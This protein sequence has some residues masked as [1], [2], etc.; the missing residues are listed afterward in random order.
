MLKQLKNL[1]NPT[2]ELLVMGI[3]N[4]TPDSFYD[5]GEFLNIND[6]IKQANKMIQEGVDIIDLGGFTSNNSTIKSSGCCAL[7][8]YALKILAGKSFKFLVT[9]MLAFA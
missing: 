3:L 9:M 6:A 7:I 2:K 1:S 5:G 8:L 4:V